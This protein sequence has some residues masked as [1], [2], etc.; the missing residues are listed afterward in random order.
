M[1]EFPEA[2]LH[3]ICEDSKRSEGKRPELFDLRH[4]RSEFP[5]RPAQALEASNGRKLETA[6]AVTGI[7][8]YETKLQ[9]HNI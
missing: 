8:T 7:Q 4:R 1:S 3:P 2:A 9:R 5:G 6:V